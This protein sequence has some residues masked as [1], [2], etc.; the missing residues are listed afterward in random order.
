MIE[1]STAECDVLVIGGGIHGTFIARELAAAGYAVVLA[2]QGD[3]GEGATGRSS[4]ILNNGLVFFES[5]AVSLRSLLL[6]PSRL[7]YTIRAISRYQEARR[8][9]ARKAGE[10]IRPFKAYLPVYRHRGPSR[11]KIVLGIWL[12]RLL[13]SRAAPARFRCIQGIALRDDPRFRDLAD[14]ENLACVYEFDEYYYDTAQEMA[15]DNAAGAANFGAQV[16]A[17]TGVRGLSR[18]G[19]RWKAELS[20]RTGGGLEVS[21]KAVVNASGPWIDDVFELLEN[22]PEAKIDKRKG[23]HIS[24]RLPEAWRGSGVYLVT[25]CGKSRF[26]LPRGEDHIFGVTNTPFSGDPA[27][28]QPTEDEIASLVAQLNEVL[29]NL[30]LTPSRV[31]YA[32]SGVRPATRLAHSAN[33]KHVHSG[34]HRLWHLSGEGLPNMYAV[35]GAS[36]GSQFAVAREVLKHITLEF[37]RRQASA[38]KNHTGD[39]QH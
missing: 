16:L 29:P 5:G 34:L 22:P 30:G 1:H 8:E 21:A 25:P 13:S 28:A 20:S 2:E 15:R 33:G 10:R 31:S 12:I 27:T 38:A 18:A 3:F 7:G 26:I 9:M 24:V 39:P 17:S 36:I 6:N 11:W 4:G 32:W 37:G 23:T 35:T 14:S 19:E